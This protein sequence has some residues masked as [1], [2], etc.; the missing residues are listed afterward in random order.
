M[1]GERDLNLRL[2]QG[3]VIQKQVQHHPISLDFEDTGELADQI[4]GRDKLLRSKLQQLAGNF[5]FDGCW[6]ITGDQMALINQTDLVTAFRFIHIWSTD[7]DRQVIFAS[8]VA[9]QIPELAPT[10]R[11]DAQGRFIQ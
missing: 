4:A 8:Q 3:Q 11:I 7:K 6:S 5:L 10:D 1:S 2:A 9:E